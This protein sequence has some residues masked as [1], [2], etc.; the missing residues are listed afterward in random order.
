[1]SVDANLV[2]LIDAG[3]K[4]D[5]FDT[6]RP[7]PLLCCDVEGLLAIVPLLNE[8]QGDV[9]VSEGVGRHCHRS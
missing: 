7:A 5:F 6:Y 3:A 1:M 2:G 9:D 4:V 8:A